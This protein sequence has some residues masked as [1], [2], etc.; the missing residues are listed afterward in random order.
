MLNARIDAVQKRIAERR[1]LFETTRRPQIAVIRRDMERIARQDCE[2]AKGLLAEMVPLRVVK[3]EPPPP[4]RAM[5][6]DDDDEFKGFKGT[7]P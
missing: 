6:E 7:A 4:M 5:D 1:K 2:Y 3:A